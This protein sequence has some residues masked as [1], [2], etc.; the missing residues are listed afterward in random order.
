MSLPA[1]ASASSTSM[2]TVPQDTKPAELTVTDPT[3]P[4]PTKRGWRFWVIFLAL[5][6]SLFLT[7]LDL[8]SVYT[9]LPS[10]VHDLEGADSFVWISSVYTLSCAAV[11]PMSGRLADIF[12]RQIVLLGAIILFAAGSAV[13]GAATSMGMIIAGRTIQGV[14]SGAIQVL[15]AI[16]TAD[17]IPLKERG[18]F[19]SITGA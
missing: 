18:L 10:I 6:L 19:Q 8:A 9:A 11:L 5:C 17:L 16:V 15:V 7:A 4:P 1:S 3:P 2:G 12:G 14:G 13:T